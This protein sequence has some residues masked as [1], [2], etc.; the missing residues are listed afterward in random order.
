MHDLHVN[1]PV[2][3]HLLSHTYALSF[4]SPN[5]SEKINSQMKNIIYFTS[6]IY[7][8][9]MILYTYNII[10]YISIIN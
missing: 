9:I 6:C 4:H 10:I 5:L 2:L 7:V 8:I 1:L 3:N